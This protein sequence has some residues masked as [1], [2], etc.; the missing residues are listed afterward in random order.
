MMATGRPRVAGAWARAF[1]PRTPTGAVLWEIWT[2][3]RWGF[4]AQ[5][6]GLLVSIALT[7]WARSLPELAANFL[8]MMSIGCFA[9][10]LIQT[11]ASFGYLEVDTRRVQSGLPTRLL[12]KPVTTA[13]IVA[14]PMLLAAAASTVVF[15]TWAEL[16]LS[17]AGLSFPLDRL[18][19]SAAIVSF[20]WWG[21]V[22]SWSFPHLPWGRATIFVVTGCAN[23]LLGAGPWL[24]PQ[25][26]AGRWRWILAAMLATAPLIALAGVRRGRHGAWESGSSWP[27]TTPSARPAR[28]RAKRFRTAFRAQFWLEWRRQ[29]V[30]LPGV[31]VCLMLVAPLL[32]L[33]PKM[34]GENGAN[35]EASLLTLLAGLL[36]IP[37]LLSGVMA[38]AMAKFD[39]G[40]SLDEMPVFIA[41]RPMTNGG[42]LLAKLAVAALASVSSWLVVLLFDLVFMAVYGRGTFFS[43]VAQMMAAHGVLIF[44]A[45]CL[46]PIL[47]LMLWTW[48]NLVENFWAALI[49]PLRNVWIPLKIVV[50]GACAWA[51]VWARID[52][53]FGARLLAW[54]PWVPW[55]IGATLIGKVALA[56]A[57]FAA[58]LRRKA[59]TPG[60]IAWI[61]GGWVGGGLF[62][63]G[64]AALACAFSPKAEYWPWVAALGPC[65]MPLAGLALAPLAIARNRHG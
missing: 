14:T 17:H 35:D 9:G 24:F 46:P 25:V 27:A 23:L 64:Y 28:R 33:V 6:A 59:I 62:F 65:F 38:P 36:P 40:Q 39:Q 55:V 53:E 42:F 11:L 13:R 31:C 47:F 56:I 19:L 18:W 2:R 29:G 57:S 61:A 41:I 43:G 12:L 30:L 54:L 51:V 20:S 26:P 32:I 16:V 52:A 8:I 15:L 49:G 3:N 48:K 50:F 22:V 60:A 58:G 5:A 7:R 34:Q 44:L 37:L 63:G 4:A 45:G 1:A 21:Q 10:A